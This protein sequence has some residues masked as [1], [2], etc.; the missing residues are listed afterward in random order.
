LYSSFIF[1]KYIIGKAEC[2]YFFMNDHKSTIPFLAKSDTSVG[3]LATL[4]LVARST[5]E[6][7][8]GLGRMKGR[9]IWGIAQDL[10]SGTH[11]V[12]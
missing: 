6:V 7:F 2:Y 3:D 1:N 12:I 8:S 9:S 4:A 5:T 11:L 10:A